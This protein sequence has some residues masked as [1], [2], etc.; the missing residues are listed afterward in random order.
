MATGIC[1]TQSGNVKRY[2][3]SGNS[4]VPWC[5]LVKEPDEYNDKINEQYNGVI[6]YK[7]NN[8][9]TTNEYCEYDVN[10]NTSHFPRYSYFS[11]GVKDD[12]MPLIFVTYYP[13]SGKNP[14]YFNFKIEGKLYNIYC[15]VKYLNNNNGNST[16]YD[17]YDDSSQDFGDKFGVNN[18][19]YSFISYKDLYNNYRDGYN[20]GGLYSTMDDTGSDTLETTI[21]LECIKPGGCVKN[22]SVDFE[23][24]LISEDE[25]PS[26][27]INSPS[28]NGTISPT[29]EI[30]DDRIYNKGNR[31]GISSG[32]YAM[33]SPSSSTEE[34]KRWSTALT[35]GNKCNFSMSCNNLCTIDSRAWSLGSLSGIYTIVKNRY[36]TTIPYLKLN[37][38]W[39]MNN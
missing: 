5:I 33:D 2:E 23:F 19:N 11:K 1:Y 8:E 28:I 9:G 12:N 14:Y 36:S 26:D 6:T 4:K 17:D 16:A 31:W 13:S 20:L 38:I 34:Y 7:I 24:F 35:I 21:R 29:S 30:V 27:Y 37:I 15:R 10:T 25:S 32:N 39:D 3:W 22:G 18:N